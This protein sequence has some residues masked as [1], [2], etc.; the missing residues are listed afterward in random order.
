MEFIPSQLRRATIRTLQIGGCLGGREDTGV[1][2]RERAR[3]K[4]RGTYWADG[5]VIRPG[6]AM[7]GYSEVVIRPIIPITHWRLVRH[8]NFLSLRFLL[9]ACLLVDLRLT[10]PLGVGHP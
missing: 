6:P 7:A 3:L 4:N 5:S 8:F 1:G 9:F 2:V 10:L